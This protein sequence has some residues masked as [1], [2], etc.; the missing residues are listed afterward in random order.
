MT[1]TLSAHCFFMRAD[2]AALASS[3]MTRFAGAAPGTNALMTFFFGGAF[4]MS[5]TANVG[6]AGAGSG[7]TTFSSSNLVCAASIARSR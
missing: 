7:A 5:T 6:I 1:A 3:D 4:G 2:R